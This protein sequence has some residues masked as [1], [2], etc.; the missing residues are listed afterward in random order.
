MVWLPRAISTQVDHLILPLEQKFVWVS[1]SAVA[2]RKAL[3]IDSK[4]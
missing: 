3:P 1:A 4:F 2:V